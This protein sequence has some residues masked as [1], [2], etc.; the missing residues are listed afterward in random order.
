ML[1][2]SIFLIQK[3]SNVI[4]RMVRSS[5]SSSLRSSGVSSG[6][7]RWYHLRFGAG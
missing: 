2:Q 7:N 3:D 6:E 5:F 1:L 4:G